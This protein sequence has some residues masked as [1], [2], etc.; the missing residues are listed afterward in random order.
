MRAKGYIVVGCAATALA[1]TVYNDFLTAHALFKFPVNEDT[2]DSAPDLECKFFAYPQRKELLEQCKMV[3]WDEWASNHKN[4]FEAA[5]KAL[6]EF[7]NKILVCFTDFRQILP[8]IPHG[9]KWQVLDSSMIKSFLWP[10]FT[11]FRLTEN[12]RLKARDSSDESRNQMR[13][14]SEITLAIGEGKKDCIHAVV[15]EDLNSDSVM[16]YKIPSLHHYDIT[17]EL[18]INNAMDSI[19]P[20][21]LDDKA[22]SKRCILAMTNKQVDTWNEKVQKKLETKETPIVMLKSKDELCEADDPHNILKSMLT[23]NVLNDFNG[24]GVPPHELLLRV[25]DVCLLTRTLD[26]QEKLVNNIR[27][28]I[29]QINEFS[30]RAVTLQ[31]QQS[32]VII[33]RIRFKF[34]LPYGQSFEMIRTQFPLRVAYS[35]TVNKSQSQ[36]L[37]MAFLDLTVPPFAHGHLYVALSRAKTAEGIAV[38]VNPEQIT[39][40]GIIVSNVIYTELLKDV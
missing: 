31:E 20:A 39:D 5:Y 24:K 4:I 34:R 9:D 8:V 35:M 2:D 29:L 15:V 11:K 33:P 3:L 32:V 21:N 12:L 1:A 14:Y 6:N 28:R 36:E 25:G 30:I 10:E 18:A 26:R 37:D 22:L 27:V 19:F 17:D 38:I 23:E 16:R 40:G 13:I 7:K